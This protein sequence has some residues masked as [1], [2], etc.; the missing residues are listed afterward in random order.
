[1]AEIKPLRG[2]RYALQRATDLGNVTAPPY[3]MLDSAMVDGLYAK[4]PFNTVRIT[5]NRPEPQDTCNKD[6]HVRAASF[7]NDWVGRGILRQDE[8]PAVYIYRQ[9]FTCA[10]MGEGETFERTGVVVQV[11]LVDFEEGVVLPHEKTLSG[12]KTDRYELLDAT[13]VNTGQIFG[14]IS[15]KGDFFSI[16]ASMI[17]GEPIGVFTDES[18]VE[19]QLFRC[20]D[21]SLINTL[22]STAR[23]R[24]I[25]IADGHHRYE[26]ALKFYKDTGDEAYAYT[27]MTLV[28]M[29]DPGLVIRPFHRLICKT[30]QNV[31]FLESL[32]KYF[33]LKK[34]DVPGVGAVQ[35]FLDGSIDG[36]MLY[37]DSKKQECFMLTLSPKG[38]SFLKSV[39]TDQSDLWKALSVSRINILVI[40]TIMN[41][42]LDGKVLHDVV[43]Y[44]NDPYEGCKRL[45]NSV[46]YHGGFFI[47]PLDI[48]MIQDIVTGG[49]R[50]PQKSTNFY[51][52]LFSGLVFN[53]L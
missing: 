46:R 32:P 9:R 47:K 17:K 51:P 50:M 20:T 39:F 1:M 43:E 16:I 11:K 45:G 13:R 21:S 7:F 23:D 35:G 34:V 44:V 36:E 4:S 8:S 41:L 5:Q 30:G 27:M 6:R 15:D 33:T 26:T 40:N 52:K 37:F 42:P 48:T 10:G 38:E 18:N 49:E 3:D 25:L 12:P 2:Y 29:V 14:L 53:K 19:H 24:T 22:I 28:S 31:N